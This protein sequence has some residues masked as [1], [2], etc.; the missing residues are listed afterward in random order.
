MPNKTIFTLLEIAE[1]PEKK[2]VSLP[3]VQR[4]FVWKPSQIENL[5]DSLLRGFPIGAFVLSPIKNSNKFGMLDGQQ[6][7]TSICLGFGKITFRDV[8]GKKKIF[9]KVKIFIDLE[10]PKNDSR[11]YIFRV[12]TKSH[13]W[14]YQ[15]ADNTKP[16]TSDNKRKAMN[17]YR[18]KDHLDVSLKNVF[19][20]DAVFPLP[21]DIFINAAIQRCSRKQLMRKFYSW[22]TWGLVKNNWEHKVKEIAKEKAENIYNDVELPE[23]TK[24]KE[25]LKRIYEIY[26]EVIEMVNK[27]TGQKVSVLYLNLDRF[28]RDEKKIHNNRNQQENDDEGSENDEIETLFI[29]LNAGGTALV[30]E[31]LNYSILKAHINPKLQENIENACKGLFPPSRFITI[32]YRLYQLKKKQG[33][34]ISMRIKPKQFQKNVAN[35]YVLKQF[36]EFI[37]RLIN[38]KAYNGLPLLNHARFLLEYD[39]KRNSFG[40]PFLIVSKISEVAPEVMLL[41]LYRLSEKR[42]GDELNDIDLRK[43]MIGMLTLFIWLGKGEK[44]KDHSKLVSNIWPCVESMPANVFWSSSTIERAMLDDVLI[45]FPPY[46][47]E[48]GSKN[49]AS[50]GRIEPDTDKDILEKL[51]RKT[52]FGLFLEKTFYNK[53][54]VLY[55][56]R[57]F[58]S[59]VFREGEY[60]LDDTNMPYDWD[61]IYPSVVVKRLRKHWAIKELHNSIGNRRAW[62]YSLNRSDQAAMPAVKLDPLNP[63]YYDEH[64]VE[65]KT[66]IINNEVNFWKYYFSKNKSLIG[67]A[68]EINKNLPTWSF[69]E[70]ELKNCN[71][72]NLKSNW[73]DVFEVIMERNLELYKEWYKNLKIEEL[74]PCRSKALKS[75]FHGKKW[76][77]AKKN[78]NVRGYFKYDN[79]TH[80]VSKSI[81]I[82]GDEEIYFYIS[83]YLNESNKEN[84]GKNYIKF[85]ILQE[86]GDFIRNLKITKKYKKQYYST[87][88][89]WFYGEFTLLSHYETSNLELIKNF[90]DWLETFPNNALNKLSKH[91]RGT[92][93][94][95]YKKM[96]R[97]V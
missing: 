36:E 62:P 43:R 76:G 1:W 37:V 13:P 53:D 94:N 70:G 10:K 95:K 39:G 42:D 32:A 26:D 60:D 91:F 77:D 33:D 61:H 97:K 50:I 20:Y 5:W 38:E 54:L 93:S 56:Q 6:R 67:R 55:A 64:S 74:I 63:D 11:K 44:L 40:L 49:L 68:E 46:D 35:K 21:F 65:I 85:G 89:T 59:K 73:R 51:Y 71:I 14:G 18:Q 86:E 9:D 12:I 90:K 45:A 3:N 81:P 69:C 80:L 28:N 30:G 16:L 2:K 24:E 87:G 58:L 92:L 15:K 41:F 23:I 83:Y 19:P 79:K 52:K 82:G 29:R 66:D 8:I 25:I 31:E 17:L 47:K 75:V 57:G 84:L 22:K 48:R 34:S 27:K 72:E 4:G 88:R 7:A 96:L 78:K